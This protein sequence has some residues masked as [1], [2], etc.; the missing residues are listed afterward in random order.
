MIN[1]MDSHSTPPIRR[2]SGVPG[3]DLHHL[4]K[5]SATEQTAHARPPSS[6]LTAFWRCALMY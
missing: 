5:L 2:L 3:T 6:M 1:T 4:T